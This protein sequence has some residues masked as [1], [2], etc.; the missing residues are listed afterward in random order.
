MPTERVC[1]ECS[2]PFS[3]AKASSRAIY[4]VDCRPIINRR[5]AKEWREQNPERYAETHGRYRAK[6]ENREKARQRANEWYDKNRE[7]ASERGKRY[8]EMHKEQIANR[9]RWY[10]IKATYGMDR[11]DFDDMLERQDGVC[12]NVECPNPGNGEKLLHI[13][14]DHATGKIR[15]LLCFHCNVALG[16]VEDSIDALRGL[17]KYLESS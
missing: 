5:R 4:C 8:R 11:L 10:Q 7:R 6:S 13:D 14:H 16:H 2:R 9:N 15:G 12:A 1:K 17:I 3:E